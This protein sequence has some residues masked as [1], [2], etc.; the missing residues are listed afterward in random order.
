[1]TSIRAQTRSPD[2]VSIFVDGRFAFGI[3]RDVL[4]EFELA[5]GRELTVRRQIELI[6]RDTFFKA[7]GAAYGYLSYR[8][9]SAA[10]IRRRLER[11]D[12]DADVIEDVVHVLQEAGLVDDRRFARAYAEDRFRSGGY[13]PLRVRSD[14]RKKGVGR[15]AVD[16]AIAD[17][18]S[19]R[20]ELLGRVREL[21]AKRWNQL[22]R[23]ADLRKRRKKV[24][25]YLARRGF[26][27]E[28]VR[29]IVNELEAAP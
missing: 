2:R 25:D 19:E 26:N 14:L 17:V 8:D 3:H 5:K 29:R 15:A 7:R 27:Y 16:A 9:R 4:L 13:G 18:F 28:M 12:Y 24:Y 10:E 6:R 22:S 20:G 11:D 1:M 21:G 23:E